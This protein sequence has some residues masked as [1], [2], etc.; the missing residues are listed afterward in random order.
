MRRS[1]G[2]TGLGPG[3]VIGADGGPRGS[4]V[5]AIGCP[6]SPPSHRVIP[7]TDDLFQLIRMPDCRVAVLDIPIGL[8]TAG[9]RSCDREAR[10]WLRGRAACVFSAPP[11][12]VLAAR[13]QAEASRIWRAVDGRGCPAQTFGILRRIAEVDRLIS[14]ADPVLEGHPELGFLT[15][16]NGAEIPSKHRPDGIAAR[17]RLLADEGIAATWA[18][19]GAR[20]LIED[21]LDAAALWWTAARVATGQATTVPDGTP[22]RD[23]RRLQMRIHV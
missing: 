7:S 17:T 6:G 18:D 20:R 19:G 11:R 3:V 15:M 16:A 9:T 13:T 2:G 5:V 14:P 12:P 10:R 23:L 22:E 4:W 8:P 21:S 1:P